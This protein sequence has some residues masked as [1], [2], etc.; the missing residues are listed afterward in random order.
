MWRAYLLVDAC[1][2]RVFGGASSV[3]ASRWDRRGVDVAGDVG[4]ADV[5]GVPDVDVA[6]KFGLSRSRSLHEG[7]RAMSARPS[8]NLRVVSAPSQ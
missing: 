1:L 4:F 2:V 5:I 8:D 6:T 3:D 7:R